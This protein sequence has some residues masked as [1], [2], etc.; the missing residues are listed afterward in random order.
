[1][2]NLCDT[3]HSSGGVISDD[4]DDVSA[5]EGATL[6]DDDMCALRLASF[7]Q[8]VHSSQTGFDTDLG[9]PREQ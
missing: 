1:M 9:D 4:D 6:N 8:G 3:M 5:N 2:L 7:V